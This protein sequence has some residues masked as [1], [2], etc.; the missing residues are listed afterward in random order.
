MKLFKSLMLAT[1]LFAV[2]YECYAQNNV[3]EQDSVYLVVDN[4]PE[5]VGGS[6]AMTRFFHENVKYPEEAYMRGIEGYVLVQTVIDENGYVT[7]P[8]I[9]RS[10]DVALDKEALRVVGGMPRWI[11]G[12]KEGKPVKVKF[13]FP[14]NFKLT[15]P[16][17]LPPRSDSTFSKGYRDNDKAIHIPLSRG[18]AGIWKLTAIKDPL[19]NVI[20]FKSNNLK[21]F[22]HDGTLYTVVTGG[23]LSNGTEIPTAIGFFGVYYDV[24][25]NTYLEKTIRNYQNPAFDGIVAELKYEIVDGDTLNVQYRRQGTDDNWM[26]EIWTRVAAFGGQKAE[27]GLPSVSTPGIQA[28]V[29]KEIKDFYVL[30]AANV[31]DSRQAGNEKLK[32]E[33]ML[34]SLMAR[35][36]L[37]KA[38]TM[39]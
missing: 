39:F 9:L 30:Y 5:F 6:A 24:A 28:E 19:G 16:R 10:I 27:R 25:E 33:R 14:V 31:A 20:N 36:R 21:I 18:L 4:L 12:K 22:N 17:D 35:I 8:V 26:Y 32:Q 38:T 37:L 3:N 13:T 2:G 29:I 7:N 1:A 15:A 34:V 23:M 11:P